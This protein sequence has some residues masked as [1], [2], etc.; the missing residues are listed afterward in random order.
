[1]GEL[2]NLKELETILIII[3]GSVLLFFCSVLF[4]I[5]KYNRKQRENRVEK[6]ILQ[7]KFESEKLASQL[8]TT[9]QT[10]KDISE[11][12][13]DNLGQKL[14]IAIQGARKSLGQEH[15]LNS[16]LEE[17]L[18]DLRQI[19]KNMNSDFLAHLGLDLAIERECKRVNSATDVNC[20][21]TATEEFLGLT[22]DQEI[23]LFR[24]FQELTN[25]ALKYS[26]SKKLDV[27][28]NRT[29]DSVVL[30][31]KD[32]GIGFEENKT[33]SGVGML[34]LRNR[35]SLLNGKIMLTSSTN[36]GTEAIIKIPVEPS[37]DDIN[38]DSG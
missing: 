34:S 29:P 9:E 30:K 16:L 36:Q 3:M 7:Q 31:V 11:E 21:Y 13:H 27:S 14:T 6:Q 2:I 12:L 33:E 8:E 38:S 23:I 24:C 4:F 19:S 22:P 20:T 15:E 37:V 35:V 32:Y 5:F 1:M 28:L 18:S 10:M 25:N 17:T 26:E